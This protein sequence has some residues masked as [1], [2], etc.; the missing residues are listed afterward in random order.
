VV[1]AEHVLTSVRRDRPEVNVARPAAPV[2]IVLVAVAVEVEPAA[3]DDRIR[4]C[5]RRRTRLVDARDGVGARQAD[6]PNE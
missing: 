4:R 1:E 6:D 2:T 5:P 3:I